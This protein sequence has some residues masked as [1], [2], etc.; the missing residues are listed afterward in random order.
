[1]SN[2][3][4]CYESFRVYPEQVHP[5]EVS[6]IL[7]IE[8]TEKNIVGTVKTN[9]LGRA[10]IITKSGWFLSSKNILNQLFWLNILIGCLI[11]LYQPS[12]D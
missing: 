10:R 5:N 3:Y 11:F 6:N 7:Q 8:P 4:E 2:S 12:K 1:M 9:S